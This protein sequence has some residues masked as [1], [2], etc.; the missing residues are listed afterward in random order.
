MGTGDHVG[1]IGTCSECKKQKKISLEWDRGT[2]AE[3]N[4]HTPYLKCEDCM[5]LNPEKKEK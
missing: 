3:G 1:E 2:D 5:L 4:I